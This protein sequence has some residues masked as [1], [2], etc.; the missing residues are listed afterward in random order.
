VSVTELRFA[1][2]N[3][4]A[5]SALLVRAEDKLGGIITLVFRN[6]LDGIEYALNV[7]FLVR[8][9]SGGLDVLLSLCFRLE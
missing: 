5:A 7:S 3:I 9:Y 8:S 4:E 1:G 2:L 6:A